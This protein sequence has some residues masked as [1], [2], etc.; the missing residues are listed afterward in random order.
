MDLNLSKARPITLGLSSNDIRVPVT[1]EH[2]PLVVPPMPKI[3]VDGNPDEWEALPVVA[4]GEG[5]VASLKAF[6]RNGKISVLAQAQSFDQETNL[7]IDSD[8]NPETGYQGWE[9]KRT[10]ADYL[11]QNGTLFKGTGA[12][13]AWEEI[14]PVPWVV[15]DA[16]ETGQKFLETEIDLSSYVNGGETM[17]VALG[18]GGEY[19]PAK[20][21][22]GE[23]ALAAVLPAV[24]LPLTERMRTGQVLTTSH[25]RKRRNHHAEGRA[26]QEKGLPACGR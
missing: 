18:V 11:V 26:G 24:P 1:S 7:F 19:A 9:Y 23:Y 15:K 6:A 12:G 10:G 13:W 4:T 22:E 5:T 16:S 3:V 14:G 2:T 8:W 21:S 25:Q 20:N 17:S